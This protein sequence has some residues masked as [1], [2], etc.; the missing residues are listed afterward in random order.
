MALNLVKT[1][2]APDFWKRLGKGIVSCFYTYIPTYVPIL[3][4]PLVHTLFRFQRPNVSQVNA[5]VQ[6]INKLLWYGT[7]NN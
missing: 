3:A 6:I 4:Y 2:P 5:L 1:S 7:I